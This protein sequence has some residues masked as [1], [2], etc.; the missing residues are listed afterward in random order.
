MEYLYAADTINV[1][2][3]NAWHAILSASPVVQLTLLTLV[4]MSV[5]CWAIVFHKRKDY[6]KVLIE[7]Q[8]FLE[9]FWDAKSFEE[10]SRGARKYKDSPLSKIFDSG[11]KELQKLVEAKKSGEANFTANPTGNI[12]RVLRDS[13][14]RELSL[15][16]S[17]LNFLATTGSTGPFIGLF[18]TVWG[19]MGAFQKIGATGSANLAVVAPGI[20]EAL[21]ATA[22][23]LL[24]AI[25]AVIAY[26]HFN[27]QLSEMDMDFS[28]FQSDF[29]NIVH[30]NFALD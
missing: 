21:I 17:K 1:N 19:I 4:I 23:G 24:A 26:N 29:I 30:R 27:N 16:E 28:Q 12:Q 20:S 13:S 6:R 18:G 11:Y 22:V 2:H 14:N 25:P 3:M 7:N 9:F 8:N 15:L 5:I 10:I